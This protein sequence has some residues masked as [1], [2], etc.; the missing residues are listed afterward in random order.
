MKR[1]N[2]DYI[3]IKVTKNNEVFFIGKCKDFSNKYNVSLTLI[4][5]IINNK[6]KNYQGIS[7]EVINPWHNKIIMCKKIG[8]NKF[9]VIDI[10]K[11]KYISNKYYLSE[12]CIRAALKNNRPTRDDYYF[13]KCDNDY[14]INQIIKKLAK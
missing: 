13:F 10:G 2:L 4:S 14:K 5:L 11:V 12:G 7:I 3:Y 1:D 6:Y 8:D 9:L